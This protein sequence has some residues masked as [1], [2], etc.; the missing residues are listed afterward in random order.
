MDFKGLVKTIIDSVLTP[1]TVLVVALALFFFLWGVLKYLR[2]A[3]DEGARKEGTAMMT[4]GIIALFVMVS[5]WGLVNVIKNTFTLDY[6]K[7]NV[8]TTSGG[9]TTITLPPGADTEGF[10]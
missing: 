10:R 9:G 5:V 3:G 4:Y 1:L 8:P 7:P 6:T 2:S